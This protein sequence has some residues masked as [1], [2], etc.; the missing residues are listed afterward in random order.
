MLKNCR[1]LHCALRASVEMT[2]LLVEIET[3][4]FVGAVLVCWRAVLLA[5]H[6]DCVDDVDYTVGLE[7]VCGG[8]PGGAAL[9]IG[10]LDL[11]HVFREG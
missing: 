5:G 2:K 4:P 1:S 6:Q 9:F 3:A 8:D 10:D 7:Y 11:A